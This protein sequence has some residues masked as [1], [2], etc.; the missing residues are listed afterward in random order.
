[1]NIDTPEIIKS[2]LAAARLAGAALAEVEVRA[3][4]LPA[5][6]RRP[7][8]LPPGKQA[9]YAF[10]VE[11]GCLKVGKAGPKTQAR[12]TSQHYGDKAP[13]TLAKSTIADRGWMMGLVSDSGRAA[14]ERLTIETVG[15][16]LELNTSRFHLFLGAADNGCVLSLAEAFLQCRFRPVYEGKGG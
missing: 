6:H 9:V 5:P 2:F 10:L 7:T 8:S 16:W 14:V 4:I 12:F 3:E 11:G 13:S 15:T 1:M